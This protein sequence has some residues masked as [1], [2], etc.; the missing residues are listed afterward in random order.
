M[1]FEKLQKK[2]SFQIT[3][4][5]CR[6]SDV[7]HSLAGVLAVPSSLYHLGQLYS[8]TINSS[9]NWELVRKANT[10][11]PAQITCIRCLE[12]GPRKWFYQALLGI[13]MYTKLQEGLILGKSDTCWAPV[14]SFTLPTLVRGQVTIVSL[15]LSL[16]L[17]KQYRSNYFQVGR[18]ST[19][20]FF[21]DVQPTRRE[22]AALL[23][24]S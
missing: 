16:F 13:L 20:C 23:K 11:A 22:K 9:I 18:I 6:A 7:S 10:W 3:G 14:A 21:L 8:V 4:E 1:P 15:H 5:T 19:V 2:L 12:V 17:R 24:A